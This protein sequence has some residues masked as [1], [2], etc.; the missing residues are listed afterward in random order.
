MGQVSTLSSRLSMHP[1]PLVISD[2]ERRTLLR[3]TRLPTSTQRLAFRARIVLARAA[4]TSVR[5]NRPSA[6]LLPPDG[7]QVVVPHGCT[8]HP[9]TP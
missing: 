4:G 6:R 3:A 7:P 8:A 5:A 9:R 2:E 1:T